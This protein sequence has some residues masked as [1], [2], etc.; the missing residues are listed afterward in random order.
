LGPFIFSP[1][2]EVFG[3][4]PMFRI[5]ATLFLVFNLACGFS[6]THYQLGLFRF[7]A[8]FF[9]GAPLSLSFS[10]LAEMWGDRRGKPLCLNILAT[11]VG[12]C[13]GAAIG[14][15]IREKLSWRILFWVTS[16]IGGGSIFVASI[17]IPE[18]QS[19]AVHNLVV[20]FRIEKRVFST[21]AYIAIL[22]VKGSS[23]ISNENL[24]EGIRNDCPGPSCN[25]M[26]RVCDA[27]TRPAYIS[28]T[29]PLVIVIGIQ[30]G[31][32]IKVSGCHCLYMT[33]G[34]IISSKVGT[35]RLSRLCDWL[36]IKI[37]SARGKREYELRCMIPGTIILAVGSVMF[38]LARYFHAAVM[39]LDISLLLLGGAIILSSRKTTTYI[40]D[41]HKH[42]SASAFAVST[43]FQRLSGFLVP[44]IVN[45][46]KT[47][48]PPTNLEIFLPILTL[49]FILPTPWF[50][51]CFGSRLEKSLKS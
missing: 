49:I 37:S 50:L 25:L 38:A 8:G 7:I 18:S 20:K 48:I 31:L 15:L 3:R 2:S 47:M 14:C 51:F 44:L 22:Q 13:T 45:F 11:L 4:A 28:F 10:V 32:D 1:A 42:H 17:F 41:K 30:L 16:A 24:G 33:I 6:R 35:R 43:S 34:A 5:G 19:L 27:L 40:L 21:L 12:P 26:Q 46:T 23:S 36:H 29:Q 39:F 9:A